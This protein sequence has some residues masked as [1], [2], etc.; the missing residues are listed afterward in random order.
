MGD[1]IFS[2][3]AKKPVKKTV[4]RNWW[5]IWEPKTTTI[6]TKQQS[7]FSIVI[8]EN[9]FQLIK[10]TGEAAGTVS[11]LLYRALAGVTV[12]NVSHVQVE[13]LQKPTQYIATEATGS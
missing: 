1:Y 4:K 8:T 11:T 6:E 10:N 12:K 13:A 9:E 3:Y 5:A 7:R 2:F